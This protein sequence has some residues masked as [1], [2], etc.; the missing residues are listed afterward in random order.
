MA[1]RA[2]NDCGTPIFDQR[3]LKCGVCLR[4]VGVVALMPPVPPAIN[5]KEGARH[6]RHLLKLS[7]QHEINLKRRLGAEHERRATLVNTISDI[8]MDI[9][10]DE[11]DTNQE[12]CNVCRRSL[13]E[14]DGHQ[15]GCLYVVALGVLA[16]AGRSVES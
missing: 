3:Y 9:A 16:E 7:E 4:R 1:E 2:C 13:I 12:Y 5:W 10:Y 6:Y 15:P 14:E 8:L 11:D